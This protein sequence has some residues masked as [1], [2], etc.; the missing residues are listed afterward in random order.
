MEEQHTVLPGV[1]CNLSVPET[2]ILNAQ[3][4]LCMCMCVCIMG[5]WSFLSVQSAWYLAF[6]GHLDTQ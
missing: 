2:A 5:L 6:E 3:A 1:S 4:D